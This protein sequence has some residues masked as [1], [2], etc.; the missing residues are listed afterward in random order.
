LVTN[1]IY[2][3]TIWANL[4]IETMT[5]QTYVEQKRVLKN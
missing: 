4:S 2:A 1:P 5:Q 3:I